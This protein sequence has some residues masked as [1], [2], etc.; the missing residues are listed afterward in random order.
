MTSPQDIRKVI[1]SEFRLYE[2]AFAQSLQTD[3][4]FLAEVLDYIHSKRGKQLRPIMVLLSAALCR[5]VTDKTLQT[6]VALELMH[7]ASLIHDD[8]VDNSPMRRGSESVHAQWTNKIAVLVGDYILTRVI[9]ILA[10]LRNTTILNI[11]SNMGA[12]LTSG[13][14]LQLHSGQSMWISE[15]QYN[16]VIEQKTA[17]L[18]AACSEAGAAS[19]GATMRQMTAM[20]QF[21]LHLGMC[22]QLKDDVL[23]YSDIED[24]GKPTMN[25]IRDGKAT[26]PLLISLQRAPKEEAE[27]I[28][29]IAEALALKSPHID[30][31]E[32]E[33][34]I[35]SFVLRYEGIRYAHQEM[36]KHR[37]KALA[38][39]SIFPD[40][41]YK[42][43]LVALLG[44]AI[45]RVK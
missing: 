27:H 32:V 14:L 28:R 44:Y 10:E 18:F 4:R 6:A 45:S 37:K 13:E 12:A 11:V 3:N 33:Q 9:H 25:D 36:E 2:E 26:L 29:E 7:T 42:E 20:K 24:I 16:K 34:E 30:P 43:C 8:V 41:K 38:A 23:D 35:K 40:N 15:E 19:T 17:C 5:G 21:G 1:Q 22:F 39:L 31:F